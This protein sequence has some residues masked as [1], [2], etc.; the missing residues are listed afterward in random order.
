[1][2]LIECPDCGRKVSDRAKTCP[3]CSCPVAELIMEQRDDEDRKARIASRER[4]DARLVDCGRCGGRGWYD[5]G[6]GMIAWCI[7]CEQTGRTP[8][9]RASDGWYSVAPYAVERFIGG[10]LHA[11]TSGV[12][13]FL[14]DREPRGHQFPAPSDRVPVDPNDPKIPWTMEADAKK[15]L[16]EP[17][18]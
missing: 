4:I 16:L 10:E 7:V 18:D 12:V 11:P 14:G 13:Y 17:K 2:A 9:V 1:M 5:H 15:K 6:E 3:D 8:L